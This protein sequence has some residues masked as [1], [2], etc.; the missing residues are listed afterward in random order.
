MKG[1]LEPAGFEIVDA[2]EIKGAPGDKE[3]ES[4]AELGRKVAQRVK[5]S[6]G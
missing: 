5:E 4:A 6:L 3:L 2:L 1:L